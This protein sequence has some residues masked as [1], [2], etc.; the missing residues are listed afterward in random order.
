MMGAMIRPSGAGV[1]AWLGAVCLLASVGLLGAAAAAQAQ[2]RVS[3]RTMSDTAAPVAAAAVVAR[4]PDSD[5]VVARATSDASGAFVL[6][7]AA[8]GTYRVSVERQGF[9]AIEHQEVTLAPGTDVVLTLFPVREHLESLDVTSRGDPA[10]LSQP[11][12]EQSLS[13][14]EAM[15]VPFN[16][17]HGVKNALRTLPSVV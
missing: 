6:E 11:S 1:R 17:S 8:T 10:S 12:G 16:G 3:G 15:N 5:A 7:I 4:T 2:V 13:G 9:Y 14:A